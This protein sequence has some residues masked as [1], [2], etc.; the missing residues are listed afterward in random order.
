MAKQVNL[1]R[2]GIIKEGY[3][4]FSW[5]SFFFGFFVPLFRKDWVTAGVMF[6]LTMAVGFF[7]AGFGSLIWSVLL[8]F[9]YNKYYTKNLIEKEG[10]LPM[11]DAD[12]LILKQHEIFTKNSNN[13]SKNDTSFSKEQINTENLS[14]TSVNSPNQVFTQRIITENINLTRGDIMNDNSKTNQYDVE[15]EKLK[16]EK[17]TDDTK[18]MRDIIEKNATNEHD[19]NISSSN[20]EVDKL[21][22]DVDKTKTLQGDQESRD[23]QEH[24]QKMRLMELELEKLKLT[25]GNQ[26]ARDSQN[27]SKN[28][29][30]F[31][32][33]A[34]VAV[35]LIVGAGIYFKSI[36]SIK[37][38]GEA[39]TKMKQIDNQVEIMKTSQGN[40]ES[41]D[42]QAH[43]AEMKRMTID[44]EQEKL[45][46]EREIEETRKKAQA[47]ALALKAQIESQRLAAKRKLD[48][49]IAE[50]KRKK[51]LEISRINAARQKEENEM[52]LLNSIKSN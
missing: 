30:A 11:S 50:A 36:N 17:S 21:K 16:L 29:I 5:T 46:I 41:R 31:I 52:R 34:V 23:K 24:D 9:G 18:Y 47:E 37:A 1:A 33:A 26:E 13:F 38:E 35:T 8:G 32:G 15:L 27:N 48:A 14:G 51:D 19:A 20:A 2:N 45:K 6:L 40:Q 4:G 10:Y 44:A 28:K 42:A 49:E 3:L 7:T 22:V 12:E 43:E 39:A 25:N